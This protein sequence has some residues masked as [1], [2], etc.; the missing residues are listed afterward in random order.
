MS[1]GF[2]A[3]VCELLLLDVKPAIITHI[4]KKLTLSY[5]HAMAAKLG[6]VIFTLL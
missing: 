3:D 2:K 4:I 1:N 5:E 6:V